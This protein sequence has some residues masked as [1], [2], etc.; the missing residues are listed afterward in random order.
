MGCGH[1]GQRAPQPSVPCRQPRAP[2]RGL[3]SPSCCP[4]GPHTLVCPGTQRPVSVCATPAS[5]LSLA[6]VLAQTLRNVCPGTDWLWSG[7]GHRSPQT[8]AGL[9]AA[10][11]GKTGRGRGQRGGDWETSGAQRC[12][13]ASTWPSDAA[14]HDAGSDETVS[15]GSDS[16]SL[17]PSFRITAWYYGMPASQGY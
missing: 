14:V 3:G 1:V 2:R 12:G 5:A 16:T 9:S 7:S 15:R 4:P 10:D 13:A 8:H 17:H 6:H 11:G